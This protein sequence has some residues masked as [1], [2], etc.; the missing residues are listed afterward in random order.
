M[1]ANTVVMAIGVDN[2]RGHSQPRIVIVH[3]DSVQVSDTQYR[4]A[5]E[6]FTRQANTGNY[7]RA[8]IAAIEVL[9]APDQKQ[10]QDGKD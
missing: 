4:H 7:N 5:T 1:D 2:S 6:V 8:T 10:K 9:Q 3:G